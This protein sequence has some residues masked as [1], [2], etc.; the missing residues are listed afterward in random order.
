[1]LKRVVPLATVAA[2]SVV[3]SS[4]ATPEI[5]EELVV[6]GTY[7]AVPELTASMSVLDHEDI[8]S[9]NKRSLSEVLQ[10][11]PGVLV[12]QQGGPGGLNAVSIRGAEANFTLVLLDGVPVSD[13]TNTRGGGFDFANLNPGVVERIEIVRGA[14]SAVYGSDALAGVINIVTRRPTAGHEEQVGVELGEDDFASYFAAA[15]GAGNNWDYSVDFS[16]QDD[17]EPLPGS[18]REND[19]A[20]LRFGWK[21]QEQ[22]RLQFGYRYLDGKR[23]S[24]PE[25]S[26]G[27][28]YASSDNLDSSEYRD[29]VFSLDWTARLNRRWQSRLG[30]N[31]FEHEEDFRSPGIAPHMDVPPNAA[32]TDF[33]RDRFQWVNTIQFNSETQLLL[34]TDYQDEE[35]D[36]AG[37]LDYFGTMFPTS[38]HL[39]RST[40]GLFASVFSTALTDL[41]VQ[42]SV[43]QDNP[44][45]FD[46]ETSF[47]VG[48][49]YHLS[50]ALSINANWGEAYKL[51]SFFALGHPLVGNPELAPETATSWDL[52][53]HWQVS[54]KLGLGATAFANDF[55][56]LI[57]FD[58]ESFRNVNRKNIQ[59]SGL[60]LQAEWTVADTLDV[61]GQATWTDIDVKGEATVLTGR[62]EWVASLVA[63]WQ[64]AEHW[65]STLDYRY[66]GEQWAVSRHTG[67][68]QALELD[69]YHRV[70]WVL[71]WS[72][73]EQWQLQLSADNLFDKD[74]GTSV[75]FPAPGRSFRLGI[76]YGN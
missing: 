47:S 71:Y 54:D 1:M 7:A 33:R 27:P 58:S 32:Q 31:R 59:T 40:S 45:E 57:D 18:T 65:Y 61:N 17:G 76:R 48:A 22:H 74:Y 51:P 73:R 41:L 36:S 72:P 13:P 53:I 49:R 8:R 26:G 11:V 64:I 34:G 70:D 30:A 52:G 12:E 15:Q 68:D 29:E 62:P 35:G 24:Y 2:L 44:D 23:T 67:R 19:T 14:Q 21:P 9:L 28:E 69:G 16:R 42:A 4:L 37:Y 66:N 39:D 25:Q 60:E 3:N 50:A 56:D 46:P 20:N 75:G 43:R 5:Q 6:T 63:R 55:D 10:T 38:Y